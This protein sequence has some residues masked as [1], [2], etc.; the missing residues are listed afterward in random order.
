LIA[1]LDVAYGDARA[2]TACVL[3]ESWGL[4]H[5]SAE[6][7][8]M[9]DVPGDYVPG[10]FFERELPCLL[11][12]LD[13]LDAA[14]D[15]IVVDGYVWL[16]GT[17]RPGLGAHLF[18]ALGRRIPVVGVAKNPFAGAVEAA[19]LL[20]GDSERPLFVSA[21]GMAVDEALHAIATMHG[22]Y[23]IPTLLR[24][25]DQLARQRLAEEK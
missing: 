18:E 14:P 6:H 5:P 24:R 3:F 7:T 1:A 25:V 4:E 23:R 10:R 11:D 17:E 8:A 13:G 12:L 20:R 2:A 22:P 15:I 9:L 19:P 16:G 21:A